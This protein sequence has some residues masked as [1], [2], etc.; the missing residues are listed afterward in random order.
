QSLH[1][2]F[3][4]ESILPGAWALE[5]SQYFGAIGRGL[6]F[7]RPPEEQGYVRISGVFRP[8]EQYLDDL[9][10]ILAGQALAG[11]CQMT[12][13]NPTRLRSSEADQAVPDARRH[14]PGI[15]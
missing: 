13:D 6:V 4:D 5:Q 10:A 15:P 12:P 14:L 1:D 9:Q 2:C 11:A 7:D 3:T 8:L